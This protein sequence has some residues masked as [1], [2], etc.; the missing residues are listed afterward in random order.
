MKFLCCMLLLAGAVAEVAVTQL[1]SRP[2]DV[3]KKELVQ[4]YTMYGNETAVSSSGFGAVAKQ[5]WDS[6]K[7]SASSAPT[8]TPS[9]L[10]SEMMTRETDA[11]SSAIP[12]GIAVFKKRCKNGD[13]AYLHIA[14]VSETAFTFNSMFVECETTRDI[15]MR[16]VLKS[17]LSLWTLGIAKPLKTEDQSPCKGAGVVRKEV[18]DICYSGDC[19]HAF[20]TVSSA[21]PECLD[22]ITTGFN[23]LSRLSIVG[24]ARAAGVEVPSAPLA[25]PAPFR[26]ALRAGAAED[27]KEKEP[28]KKENKSFSGSMKILDEGITS[29]VHAVKEVLSIFSTK[30]TSQIIGEQ[31]CLGFDQFK[32]KSVVNVIECLDD[33]KSVDFVDAYFHDVLW[34]FGGDKEKMRGQLIAWEYSRGTNFTADDM[35]F[36]NTADST[37][38][39]MKIFKNHPTDEACSNWAIVD[40]SGMFHLAPD[41]IFWQKTKSNI[42]GSKSET[43]IEK[44]PHKI[45]L[46]DVQAL[47]LFFHALAIGRLA[48]ARGIPFEWPDVPGC[49]GQKP[50][51]PPAPV[52]PVKLQEL[53]V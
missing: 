27:K 23:L 32:S 46:E 49:G 41:L 39:L 45:S 14:A 50:T 18:L 10:L 36:T 15:M 48:E 38:R 30:S 37:V 4:L 26:P 6:M 47:Q 19:S 7:S 22:D 3:L 51:N 53:R 16:E 28:E 44:V 34:A 2:R 42:F 24:T 13:A 9:D 33:S 31:T 21:S 12:A 8:K 11:Q 29:A 52:E 40:Y 1:A 17:K 20:H 43:V 35:Q 5:S 25:L